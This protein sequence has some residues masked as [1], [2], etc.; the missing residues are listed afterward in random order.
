MKMNRKKDLT[1]LKITAANKAYGDWL[2]FIKDKKTPTNDLERMSNFINRELKRKD[3]PV[4]TPAKIMAERIIGSTNDIKDFPPTEIARQKGKPVA[5]LHEIV[6]GTQPEGFGTGFLIS[7]NV[8]ITNYHVFP[9][10]EYA[11]DCAANFLHEKDAGNTIKAGLAFRLRP[12]IFFYNNATLD[13]ALVYVEKKSILGEQDLQQITFLPLLETK[14]KIITGSHLSIIQYPLGGYKKYAY[15]Q[16]IVTAIDDS[17]GIIQYTTDT[18]PASS[19]SPGFNDAWE[20]A[21][22][23]YTGIPNIIDGKWRT[24]TGQPWNAATMSEEDVLWVGNAGKSISKIVAF[25]KTIVL[26]PAAQN[27]IDEILQAARE[28]LPP[29]STAGPQTT[30][31][32]HLNDIPKTNTMGNIVLNFNA[33]AKV[34]INSNDEIANGKMNTTPGSISVVEKKLRFDE[35]YSNRKGYDEHFLPGF[36]VPFPQVKTR[37]A[38]LYKAI[39]AHAPFKFHYHHY[40]VV[41]NKVRRFLMWSAVN[42][43]YSETFRD[44]RSRDAFGDDSKAWRLDPRM[45][46]KYQVQANEFYDPATLVDK[47]HLVRREDNCW[48]NNADSLG[49]EYA[50]SDTFHWTN[51][52][53]QHEQFNRDMSG[54]H[55]L[56]GVL[57]NAIKTQLFEAAN[58]D[59][60]YGQRSCILAGP[61]LD[62]ENDPSYSDIQYPLQFWKVFVISSVSAGP[63]VYGFLL[64]QQDKVD[65]FGLE[66]EGL[67]RFN[68]QVKAMQA[69]LESIEKLSGVSFDKTLHAHDVKA[70]DAFHVNDILHADLS[71]FI[72]H[73]K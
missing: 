48:E 61:V 12:D 73:K 32:F 25:L 4:K 23:H 67:P 1:D 10:Q 50:N 6:T 51:C 54:M 19:G 15:E 7:A 30:T 49:I 53:P 21:V 41:M 16:N 3:L 13:L 37:K 28:S 29:T 45:P 46:A 57:E 22:L 31:S 33:P 26:A 63:L 64:S 72:A 40:S 47:G 14:G 5:R 35:D 43:N 68:K 69:S 65:E 60:D 24:K 42:V 62:N 52:T 66:I 55:G 34:F 44:H 27:Y 17:K 9:S 56:W 11:M 38:E 71:N 39:G 70:G 8:L 18:Q 59:K 2:S 20:V 58:P 36:K